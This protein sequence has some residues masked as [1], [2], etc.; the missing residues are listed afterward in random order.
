MRRNRYKKLIVW[1]VTFTLL[2]SIS[3]Q[4]KIVKRSDISFRDM[5]Y[6]RVEDADVDYLL[7]IGKKALET[8]DDKLISDWETAYLTLYFKLTNNIQL[9]HL[10]YELDHTDTYFY[11]E[12]MYCLALVGKMKSE[13]LALTEEKTVSEE[14]QQYYELK[15]KGQELVDLYNSYYYGTKIEYQG[16]E[17]NLTDILKSQDIDVEKKKELVYGPWYDQYNQQCGEVFLKLV[18]NDIAAAKAIGVNSVA[19]YKYQNYSRDYT[20]S[21]AKEFYKAVKAYAPP[22]YKEL[23]AKSDKMRLNLLQYSY[24]DAGKLLQTVGTVFANEYPVLK[25]SYDYLLKYELYDILT[26]SNKSPGGFTTYLS[27]YNE[28]FISLN[29]EADYQTLS[30]FIHEFGH[31]N[32][33]Y[34]T[35]GTCQSLDLGEVYS[36]G[37]EL[38]AFPYHKKMLGSIE[39][40]KEMQVVIMSDMVRGIIDGCVFDEFLQTVYANPNMTVQELNDLYGKISKEYGLEVDNRDWV[41]VEHN[42]VSPF[43][44]IS[45][46]MSAISSLEIWQK[47]QVNEQNGMEIYIK[48]IDSGK[49]LTFQEALRAVGLSNPFEEKTVKEVMETIGTYFEIGEAAQSKKA[50]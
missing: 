44:Y 48:L 45:Y 12:Y 23:K 38:L 35:G 5:Q 18:K 7:D 19:E 13:Y 25:E 36:Q 34:Y 21:Q 8:K 30:S 46:A 6:E 40:S 9:A 2:G 15:S 24:K 17:M 50:A 14:M 41:E 1:L 10:Y 29:Y 43:Y 4:A 28:P 27:G 11:N 32:Y 20:P 33:E 39:K 31:F 22:I 16:K 47:A 42:F 49:D 3:L 26:S 37:L